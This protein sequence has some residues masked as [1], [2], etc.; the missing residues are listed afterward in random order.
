LKVDEQKKSPP[1]N[2]RLGVPKKLKNHLDHGWGPS[3]GVRFL[4]PE[5]TIVGL[6]KAFEKSEKKSPA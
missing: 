1:F 5:G 6:K 2:Q 3:A 4:S